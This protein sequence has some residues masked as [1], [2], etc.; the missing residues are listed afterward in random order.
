M[1]SVGQ[2]LNIPVAIAGPYPFDANF[3]SSGGHHFTRSARAVE[4]AQ[5]EGHVNSFRAF[6]G[7][8]PQDQ[9]ESAHVPFIAGYSPLFAPVPQPVPAVPHS[10]S[11]FWR[12]AP[13]PFTST[14]ALDTF[15][16]AGAPPVFVGF[17]DSPLPAPARPFTVIA[18]ALKQLNLRGLLAAPGADHHTDTTLAA[19]TQ[20]TT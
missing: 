6:L 8:R 2:K 16:A 9:E 14:P 13:E 17:G 15:L 20:H 11:G 19:V 3:E 10:V 18:A 7:L 4:W 1:R 5:V 12:T